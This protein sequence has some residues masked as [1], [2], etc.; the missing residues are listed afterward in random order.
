MAVENGV[1]FWTVRK[2]APGNT[3]KYIKVKQTDD[4]T[5]KNYRNIKAVT[6]ASP[7][8]YIDVVLVTYDSPKDYLLVNE[9][10][11][12]PAANGIITTLNDGEI[13]TLG[14]FIIHTGA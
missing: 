5:V 7:K 13:T 8:I 2:I 3:K 1:G 10:S 4:L 12:P 9:L 6:E 11:G 14:D